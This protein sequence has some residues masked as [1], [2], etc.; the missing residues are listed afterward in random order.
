M[1]TYLFVPPV[2]RYLQESV[3]SILVENIQRQQE[4]ERV[5]TDTLCDDLHYLHCMYR[6]IGY[7]MEA[8]F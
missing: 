5:G 3:N 6:L 4:S 1:D 8:V 7:C 2:L